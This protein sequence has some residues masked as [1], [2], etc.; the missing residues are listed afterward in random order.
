MSEL[1]D[2]RAF[3]EVVEGQGFSAA[4]R[5]LGVSKSIVSRRIARL[6][7][8]LGAR[9]ISRTTRGVNPTEAGM[10][11]KAR[12]ERILAELEEAR[13]AVAQSGQAIVGALRVAAPLS[14]L[15]HAA[16]VLAEL[17]AAHPL[18]KVE[19]AYSDARIDLIAERFDCA[20]RIGSLPDS[21]L[22]ARR[23]SPITG[24]LVASPAYLDVR[25]RPTTPAD[26]AQH[27]MLVRTGR[28][29]A[30]SL[31]LRSGRETVSIRLNGRFKADNG[32]ALYHAALAGLGIAA[33]PTFLLHEAINA[34]TLEVVLRD[35]ALQEAAL[36]LVR[37]PGPASGKVRVLTD[38]LVERFGGEPYWDQCRLAHPPV[39]A[40]R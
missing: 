39:S 23:I 12:G 34:G 8:D 16:P 33:L 14:F 22:V 24:I 2:I 3:V 13:D 7:S 10:E 4:A 28:L 37:P 11:F 1:E 31:P 5:R 20:I 6:E 19:T 35:Y 38:L 17:A 18:L 15:R 40:A 30:E 26:L 25:G 21:S 32:E 36:F 9:L 29:D 27:E